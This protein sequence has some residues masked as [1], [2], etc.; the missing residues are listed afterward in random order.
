MFFQGFGSGIT[1]V[2]MSQGVL[3]VSYSNKKVRLYSFEHI[4]QR[5]C[6]YMEQISNTIVYETSFS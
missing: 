1:D 2:V 5:V 6:I 4:V 3:A